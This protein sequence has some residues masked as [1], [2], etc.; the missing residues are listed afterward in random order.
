MS[1][2]VRMYEI[3]P[4]DT[5]VI[6]A[7]QGHRLERK[8]FYCIQGEFIINIVTVDNFHNPSATTKPKKIILSEKKPFILEL[9]G[10]VASGI[11]AVKSQSKLL[12]FSDFSMEQSKEDDYRFDLNFWQGDW[13]S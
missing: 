10:G 1:P 8:W 13:K 4:M 7:W 6:R 12:V 3:A 9:P 11:K 5:E 2:V